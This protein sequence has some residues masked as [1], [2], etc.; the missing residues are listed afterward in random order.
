MFRVINKID[1]VSP[2]T[3]VNYDND[4]NLSNPSNSYLITL[5]LFNKLINGY[6][7]NDVY[8]PLIHTYPEDLIY[9]LNTILS[10]GGLIDKTYFP[11]RK[12]NNDGQIWKTV[13]DLP[14]FQFN[15]NGKVKDALDKLKTYKEEIQN[16]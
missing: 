5:P 4:P 15:K 7:I 2:G 1:P 13:L 8:D 12:N 11:Y 16:R 6:N 9:F 14:K 3:I 10:D